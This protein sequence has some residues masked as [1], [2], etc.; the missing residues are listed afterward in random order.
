MVEK[1]K[2]QR[3]CFPVHS[4]AYSHRNLFGK[5]QKVNVS[6]E[7][8]RID[9]IFRINYTV[10]WIEGDDKRTQQSIMIQSSRT[11]GTF[12]H[13]NQPG[14]S[15]ITIG[16]VTAGIEFSRPIR[17]KWSGT[18]GLTFQRAGVHDEKG[19]QGFL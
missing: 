6:L 14:N 10:P 4:F 16:R 18:A 12:V 19:D 9:S 15:N 13:G 3:R 2:L 8:G 5:N 11:P 1:E 17:P 7:R